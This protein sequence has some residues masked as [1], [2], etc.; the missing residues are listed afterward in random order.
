MDDAL[1]LFRE[2]GPKALWNVRSG[3]STTTLSRP[4]RLQERLLKEQL[5][6]LASSGM[7]EQLIGGV[8]PETIYGVPERVP[9]TTY[10]DYDETLGERRADVL[11]AQPRAWTRTSGRTRTGTSGF[12][13]RPGS[14]TG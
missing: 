9:L 12:P 14:S 2:R 1:T 11:P 13:C 3:T 4:W 7:G 10:E 6:M 8:A 5:R